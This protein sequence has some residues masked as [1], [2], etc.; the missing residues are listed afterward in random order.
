MKTQRLVDRF[1]LRELWSRGELSVFSAL[2]VSDDR[3]GTTY[4]LRDGAPVLLMWEVRPNE[5]AEA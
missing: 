2:P 1:E 4:W 3:V 5:D